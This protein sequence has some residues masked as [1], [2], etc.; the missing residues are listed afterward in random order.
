[1]YSLFY[2]A[3]G[4]NGWKNM[5]SMAGAPGALTVADDTA[6]NIFSFRGHMAVINKAGWKEE[7]GKWPPRTFVRRRRERARRTR[8]YVAVES[9]S[10]GEK[11]LRHR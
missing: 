4:V 11:A 9:I 8:S 3:L 6:T 5:T 1:M 7:P 10:H 2:D